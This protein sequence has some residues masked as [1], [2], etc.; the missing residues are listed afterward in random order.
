MERAACYTTG[1]TP[2]PRKISKKPGEVSVNFLSDLWG[3]M[4]E[5]KKFWLLPLLI[6]FLLFG[7]LLFFAGGSAVA[8]FIYTLF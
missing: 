3:F 8:P 7:A 5:R 6:I 4:K 1:I 2:I